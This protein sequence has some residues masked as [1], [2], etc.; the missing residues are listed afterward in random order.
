MFDES[1][2]AEATAATGTGTASFAG[3]ASKAAAQIL[4]NRGLAI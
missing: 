2:D 3:D 1:D 4:S